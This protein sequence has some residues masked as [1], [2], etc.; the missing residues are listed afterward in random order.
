LII[1]LPRIRGAIQ[2]LGEFNACTG[3][4]VIDADDGTKVARVGKQASTNCS[5]MTST[6]KK[7]LATLER[8]IRAYLAAHPNAADSAVGIQRWWLP[9]ELAFASITQLVTAL[10]AVVATG[11]LAEHHLPDGSVIYSAVH[12]GDE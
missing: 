7:M 1:P 8:S 12:P 2:A 4:G 11:G 10:R 5:R 3:N 6:D 9:D